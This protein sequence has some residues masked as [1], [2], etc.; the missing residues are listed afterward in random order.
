MCTLEALQFFAIIGIVA[1]APA[2]RANEIK[3][4]IVRHICSAFIA[5]DTDF[6]IYLH[7]LAVRNS[8]QYRRTGIRINRPYYFISMVMPLQKYVYLAFLHNRQHR[9]AE[10]RPFC[11]LAM[12]RAAEDNFMHQSN[13]VF[14][15]RMKCH[16][17]PKPVSYIIRQ[18]V[19]CLCAI[20]IRPAPVVLL[21]IDH[22]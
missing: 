6:A 15:V 22:K 10:G 11:V 1:F 21:R 3:R 8:L 9:R 16:L 4:T 5:R 20:V 18:I 19:R 7:C 2:S 12:P 14:G 17:F 13:A